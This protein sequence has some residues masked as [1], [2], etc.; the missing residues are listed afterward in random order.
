[1]SH[2]IQRSLKVEHRESDTVL[3]EIA[4]SA[5]NF[6][7][8]EEGKENPLITGPER[9][10]ELYDAFVDWKLT[11]PRRLRF[12]EATLPSAILLQ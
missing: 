6:L 3:S 12:E 9:A 5:L 2:R 10:R 7:M 8:P 4:E 11:L 1:M